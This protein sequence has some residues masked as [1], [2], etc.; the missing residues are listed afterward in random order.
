MSKP[1]KFLYAIK[2]MYV[3]KET[4]KIH[5]PTRKMQYKL[6]HWYSIGDIIPGLCVNGFHFP[7]RHN[8]LSHEYLGDNWYHDYKKS[9]NTSLYEMRT[10]LVKVSG[11]F[12]VGDTKICSQEILIVEDTGITNK[13]QLEKYVKELIANNPGKTIYEVNNKT[14]HLAYNK[15]YTTL[16]SAGFNGWV[17]RFKI[18]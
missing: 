10:F 5:A 18:K 6:N 14:S 1:K 9:C 4:G 8:I 2:Y 7:S 15:H 11:L 3:N 13:K 12:D 17:G 16:E